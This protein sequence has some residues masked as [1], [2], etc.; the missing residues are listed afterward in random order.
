MGLRIGSLQK[1]KKKYTYVSLIPLVI[2]KQQKKFKLFI[3]CGKLKEH[4]C[5]VPSL[6]SLLQ[7]QEKQVLRRCCSSWLME[8]C[9][10]Y[11]P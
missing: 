9:H 1:K 4:L 11:F 6:P 10:F 8:V 3:N 5:S 2:T 7:R